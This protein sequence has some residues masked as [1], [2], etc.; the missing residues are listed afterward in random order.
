M[1]REIAAALAASNSYHESGSGSDS[2]KSWMEDARRQQQQQ[3][4]E[5]N[6]AS[7]SGGGGPNENEPTP[8]DDHEIMEQYRIMAEHEAHLRLKT[9]TGIDME[10]NQKRTP[11]IGRVEDG[12]RKMLLTPRLPEPRRVTVTI[13]MP[14]LQEPTLPSLPLSQEHW[15]RRS[16][17]RQ[18]SPGVIV[19]RTEEVSAEEQLLKCLGCGKELRVR[20]RAMFARCPSC[21][22]ESPAISIR[23]RVTV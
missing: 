7:W 23:Q 18:V 2:P 3:E 14:Q 13:S 22:A 17:I 16:Q 6:W 8:F 12:Y 10:D 11:V 9:T 19:S 1:E 21:S 4:E 20:R 5:S 15:G